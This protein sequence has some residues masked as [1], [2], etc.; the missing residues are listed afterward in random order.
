MNNEISLPNNNEIDL[1]ADSLDF[2]F[3]VSFEKSPSKN[4]KDAIDLAKKADKYQEIK[5]IGTNK[6]LH[7]CSFS[8]KPLSLAYALNLLKIIDKWKSTIIY[9]NG[10]KLISSWHIQNTVEC[11]LNACKCA[12]SDA[13]CSVQKETLV[14]S[15]EKDLKITTIS[16]IYIVPCKKVAAYDFNDMIIKSKFTDSFDVVE[17]I[18]VSNNC[19]WC[20][21]FNKN[22]YQRL[23]NDISTYD[24]SSIFR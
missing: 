13:Y 23:D 6:I 18:A 9:A 12:N 15:N 22:K 5:N 4:Y 1:I 14:A 24:L 2:V 16:N 21:N 20:S 19:D 8:N 17:A 3:S 11:Y 7:K 10:K